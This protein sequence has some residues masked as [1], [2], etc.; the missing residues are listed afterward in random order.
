[1][2]AESWNVPRS[3]ASKRYQLA[4]QSRSDA[5]IGFEEIDGDDDSRAEF[6]CP[7]CWKDFDIL[8][9]CCH[10]DEVHP[11]EAKNGLCPFCAM[12]VGVDMVAHMTMVHGNIFKISFYSS[13]NYNAL[14]SLTSDY[15]RKRRSRRGGSHSTLSILRKEL[16]DVNLQSL[17]GGS[18][19]VSSSNT[20]PDPLLSSFMYNMPMADEP[21]SV[22][23]HSSTEAS[24]VKE[25]SDENMLGR[26]V[27]PSPPLSG[28]DQEEKAQRCKFVQGLLLSTFL[29]DNL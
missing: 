2:D 20:A 18:S 17:L 10:I 19:I 3:T 7:F 27:Q 13:W 9:L 28:K 22:Q 12:R 11:V 25:S 1:M 15:M 14:N 24:S 4:L 8:G 29:D 5:Y 6:P 23:P 16:R 26:N 21:I